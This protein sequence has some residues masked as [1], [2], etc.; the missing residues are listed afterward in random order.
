MSNVLLAISF[1]LITSTR[2]NTY[3]D[4]EPSPQ[5]PTLTTTISAVDNVNADPRDNLNESPPP[6]WIT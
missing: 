3:T 6:R 5:T 4:K 2:T 1:L